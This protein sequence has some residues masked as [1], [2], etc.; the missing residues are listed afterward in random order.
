MDTELLN[1]QQAVEERCAKQAEH[2]NAVA[3]SCHYCKFPGA[4][5]RETPVQK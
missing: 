4:R 1:S 3:A 2:Q 5:Q